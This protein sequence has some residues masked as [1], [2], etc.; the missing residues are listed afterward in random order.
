[1][2]Y[3]SAITNNYLRNYPKALESIKKAINL[4]NRNK[5]YYKVKE[6]IEEN[7][8]SIRLLVFGAFKIFR[9]LFVDE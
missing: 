6:N 9:D 2:F 3:Y 8:F 7:I 4:D 5:E 1:M